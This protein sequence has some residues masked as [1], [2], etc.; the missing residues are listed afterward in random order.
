MNKFVRELVFVV[1]V[2]AF[3][4]VMVLAFYYCPCN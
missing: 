2:F 1:L 4:A 3:A